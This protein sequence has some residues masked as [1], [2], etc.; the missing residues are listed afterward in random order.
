ML[1]AD[2]GSAKDLWGP[3]WGQL[4][5]S[6]LSCSCGISSINPW[7]AGVGKVNG[8]DYIGIDTQG[9]LFQ[10][11]QDN[12]FLG[13]LEPSTEKQMGWTHDLS[14]FI[15]KF[16]AM[17]HGN[18]A[19]WVSFHF[20]AKPLAQKPNLTHCLLSSGW[21][22]QVITAVFTQFSPGGLLWLVWV[23]EWLRTKQWKNYKQY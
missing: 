2:L 14:G 12:L 11:T 8:I 22:F 18:H 3:R 21:T 1:R 19:V 23:S 16:L 15:S 4:H 10:V 9:L 6:T 7:Q 5:G 17:V 13:T 20:D